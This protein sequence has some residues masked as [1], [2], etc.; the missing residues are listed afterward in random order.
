MLGSGSYIEVGFA[1]SIFSAVLLGLRRID[2]RF[3]TLEAQVKEALK[4]RLTRQEHQIW[5]L[6]MQV[7]NPTLSFP[8][9][10][11]EDA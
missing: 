10:P 5:V 8:D 1:F 2:T 4:G 6:Q 3:N 9:S 7:K 11:G